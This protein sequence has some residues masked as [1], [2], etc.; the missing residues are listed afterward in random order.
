MYHQTPNKRIQERPSHLKDNSQQTTT[1]SAP[2]TRDIV[3]IG[4]FR[5]NT[6]LVSADDPSPTKTKTTMQAISKSFSV[7]RVS[8]N[9][10]QRAAT[11]GAVRFAGTQKHIEKYASGVPKVF[12][13]DP[14]AAGTCVSFL[15]FPCALLIPVHFLC[16][17][18]FLQL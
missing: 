13:R 2:G 1:S 11:V 12:H 6:R 7:A 17:G 14:N 16:G 4:S 15:R 8:T 9:T 10:W 18:L 3:S 5:L